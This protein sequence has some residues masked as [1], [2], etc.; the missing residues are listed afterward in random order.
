[1][2]SWYTPKIFENLIFV[3]EYFVSNSA[4]VRIQIQ[5][6]IS[7]SI[8][9]KF[10][11]YLQQYNRW[12]HQYIHFSVLKKSKI[13]NPVKKATSSCYYVNWSEN[14]PVQWNTF[15]NE[16]KFIKS[17]YKHPRFFPYLHLSQVMILYMFIKLLISFHTWNKI[18]NVCLPDASKMCRKK[19]KSKAFH[20]IF[21]VLN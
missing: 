12:L 14:L 19:I 9:T 15:L 7:D 8:K 20:I 18:R 10:D 17:N 16:A 5:I 21:H 6:Q 3:E 1:M 4:V 2:F 11:W 13:D